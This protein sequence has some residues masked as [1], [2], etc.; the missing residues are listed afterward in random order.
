MINLLPDETKRQLK[1]ARLNTVLIKYIIFLVLAA[2]FLGAA[3]GIS[4]AV[5]SNSKDD[6]EKVISQNQNKLNSDTS[7]IE[8]ANQL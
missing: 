8:Q 2:I 5:L 4:Y 6:A 1:A 7:I 3:C